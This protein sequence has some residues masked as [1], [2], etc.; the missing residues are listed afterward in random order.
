MKKGKKDKALPK[1]GKGKRLNKRGDIKIPRGGPLVKYEDLGE[2]FFIKA[3]LDS[4]VDEWKRDH[5]GDKLS[6]EYFY[7]SDVGRCP[8]QI[9]YQFKSADQKRDITVGTI[10]AF[11]F[12]SIFHD[13]LQQRLRRLGYTT[14]RDVEFGT[15]HKVK[16][17][18]RGRLDILIRE[19]DGSQTIGEIKSKNPFGFDTDPD[20]EEMDQL[21][22][23]VED[24]MNN[25]YFKTRGQVVNPWGYLIYVDRSGIGK[26]S[27]KAW[28]VFHSKERIE[29]IESFFVAV[30]QALKEG[31]V[32]ERPFVRDSVSCTYCRFQDFCWAGVPVPEIP[33]HEKDESVLPPSMEIVESAAGSFISLDAQI[34]LLGKEKDI[35]ERVLTAYFKGTGADSIPVGENKVVFIVGTK[36]ILNEE[37]L[38][39]RFRDVYNAF[40][41]PQIGLLR[42]A[43]EAGL[44]DG[45]TFELAKSVAKT[46]TV[47][48]IRPKEKKEK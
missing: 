35:A 17:I 5:P 12:G 7:V 37:I 16:F 45:T 32:P 14:S 33:K 47:K 2:T 15:F 44:V 9:F 48:V 13:E 1:E 40:S 10:M 22:S 21:L 36:T 20:P 18:S 34:K 42:A 26:P 4:Y 8:R 25:P 38:W 41:K 39:E 46:E 30:D 43:V 31:I 29:F 28:K 3:I 11:R 6:R 27:I 23:Y 24:C 19:E